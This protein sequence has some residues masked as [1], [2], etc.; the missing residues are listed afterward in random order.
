VNNVRYALGPLLSNVEA[1]LVFVSV[2]TLDLTGQKRSYPIY[3]IERESVCKAQRLLPDIVDSDF[4]DLLTE[5]SVPGYPIGRGKY[6]G[7]WF[8]VLPE[9]VP[10]E[11]KAINQE[12]LIGLLE[13]KIAAGLLPPITV[14]T[15]YFV[16]TP[17]PF[18]ILLAGQPIIYAAWH[19]HKP[20]PD[21]LPALVFAVHPSVVCSAMAHE[22]AEAITNPT[23]FGWYDPNKVEGEVCDLCQDYDPVYHGYGVPTVWSQKALAC[24]LPADTGVN[25]SGGLRSAFPLV[26]IHAKGNVSCFGGIPESG[27]ATFSA[28]ARRRAQPYQIDGY[29][30]EVDL[31][32]WPF[33][34]SPVIAKGTEPTITVG[35]HAPGEFMV[36]VNATDADGCVTSAREIFFFVSDEE[37]ALQ[38]F[39]CDRVVSAIGDQVRKRPELI[40]PGDPP[41][42][43]HSI[44]AAE[45]RQQRELARRL[46][47]QLTEVI[48]RLPSPERGA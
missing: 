36:S 48:A 5:Y 14:N 15:L 42:R 32:T 7:A 30:W 29:S 6:L 26:Q 18:T 41:P 3:E 39:M 16:C 35:P 20:Q 44:L 24:V 33:G 12:D 4:M 43:I 25:G 40:P 2:E 34:T 21:G 13:A 38:E 17:R 10:E 9:A 28:S 31:T 46:L 23:G 22:L 47:R 11:T 19:S 27:T 1:V 8:F 45:V 37:F